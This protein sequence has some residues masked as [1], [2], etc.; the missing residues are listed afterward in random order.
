MLWMLEIPSS[1][2]IASSSLLHSQG[3]FMLFASSYEGWDQLLQKWMHEASHARTYWTIWRYNFLSNLEALTFSDVI[4]LILLMFLIIVFSVWLIL[5]TKTKDDYL[6]GYNDGV[7]SSLCKNAKMRYG[8]GA[9]EPIVI[10]VSDTEYRK[11]IDQVVAT[12]YCGTRLAMQ[13]PVPRGENECHTG[14]MYTEHI[15]L[16][17]WYFQR[18]YLF[19][20]RRGVSVSTSQDSGLESSMMTNSQQTQ[21]SE[22]NKKE[23]MG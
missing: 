10:I 23:P 4:V 12:R 19:L 8:P 7:Y 22:S 17:P 1:V 16:S 15:L 2:E 21:S 5:F 13:N 9:N 6:E 18:L 20:F 14:T 3:V 11:T